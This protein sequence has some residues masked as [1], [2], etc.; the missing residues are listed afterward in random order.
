MVSLSSARDASAAQ[1]ITC[2]AGTSFTLN[3]SPRVSLFWVRVPVLSAHSTSTPASSSM[4]T[5][6]L[7][8]A[9]FLA[10]RR[11]PTAIVTDKHGRHRHGDRGHG[12][13][14]GE[15]QRRE[16]RV[17]AEDRDS[18]DHRHQ[19]DREDDQVVADLQHRALKVADG[20][21]LLHQLR[22][23]AEVG[24]RARGIDQGADL[25]LADD[26]SREH[27]LAR[28]CARRAATRRS[29]RTDPP[30]PG[31]PPAAARRPARCRPGAC[32]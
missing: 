4:A 25:A 5:S 27:R 16:D 26:R 7:T 23:L 32:G 8:I 20:V 19:S 2:S 31:R 15:L 17:A 18:D 24:A 9:C 13:H 10:S 14:Q 30:P 29:A 11:A 1:R 21:R 22:R 12:Q 6:R 28:L 3:G